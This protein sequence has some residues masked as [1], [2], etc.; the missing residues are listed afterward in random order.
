M[1]VSRKVGSAVV[2]NR[3]KRCIREFYRTHRDRF[4]ADVALVVVARPAAAELDCGA[5]AE[6]LRELLAQGE[7]L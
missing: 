1:A 6:A 7:V 2:R 3:V 4:R 5:C